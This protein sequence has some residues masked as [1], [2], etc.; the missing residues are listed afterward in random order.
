MPGHTDH[1]SSIAILND[2]TIVSSSKDRSLKFWN[3]ETLECRQ[4]LPLFNRN[5]NALA[6]MPG[7]LLA[8]AVENIIKVYNLQQGDF[9]KSIAGHSKN[10]L[11]ML[12]LPDGSILSGGQD[13]VIKYWNTKNGTLIKNFYGHKDFVKSIIQINVSGILKFRTIS[14]LHQEKIK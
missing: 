11:T 4:T 5:L 2:G 1:V 9:E 13:T 8:V 10:I 7:G 3:P 6:P 14:L 12:T